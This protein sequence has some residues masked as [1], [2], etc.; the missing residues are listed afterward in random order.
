[1][2]RRWLPPLV[3]LVCPLPSFPQQSYDPDAVLLS[4][5]DRLLPELER[6]PRYTCV[7]TI[8]RRQYHSASQ[9]Q[10]SSCAKVIAA[11]EQRKH[12]LSLRS[13]DRL[14][15]EV[16]IADKQNVY[17]WVGA[18]KFDK[19]A[20]EKLAGGG[21]LGSGD[22]G[23][24]LTSILRLA[25][26]SFQKEEAVDKRRLLL[27]SYDIPL[28]RSR[29]YI[30]GDKGWMVTAYS[31]TLLLDPANSDVVSM[32]VRSGALPEN[33]LVCQALSEVDYTRIP[34]HDR[35][36][37]IPRE[38]RLRMIDPEGGESLSTVKY[39]GCR[40]Y[41]SESRLLPEAP[42]SGPAAEV[43]HES[44]PQ[45]LPA[46]L[47]FAG[48]IVTPIDSETAAAGDPVEVA[49]RQPLRDGENTIAPAGAL[50][51]ARLS[52]VE[53]QASGLTQIALRF[54]TIEL[55]GTTLALRATP[56]LT[57][58]DRS[59]FAAITSDLGPLDRSRFRDVTQ[60]SQDATSLDTT[61]LTVRGVRLQFRQLDLRWTTLP[62]E[63]VPKVP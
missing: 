33:K 1:M 4:V 3:L 6:L 55:N 56:D 25:T 61:V 17:S 29:Y 43:N 21:P 40:E 36:I 8:T 62:V 30:K 26:I 24:F 32:T 46:G 15:L 2:S 44:A 19:D 7:Q 11:H 63:P 5:R 12:E 10:R 23:P 47:H 39:S 35:A 27:Y 58:M 38:T 50:L 41:S 51:H 59:R 60:V 28:E 14:R 37:L 53:Q 31:G 34:I 42:P 54:E 52:R 18:P 13:W 48:R 16:A 57:P 49:L 22:F 9:A 20:F 45:P